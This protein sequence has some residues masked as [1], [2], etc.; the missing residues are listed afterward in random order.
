[1][2]TLATLRQRISEELGAWKTISTTAAGESG[3]TTLVSTEFSDFEEDALKEKY[4]K[5]TSGVTLETRKIQSVEALTGTVRPYRIFT[6]QIASGV[7]VELH[8]FDPTQI[9]ASINRAIRDAYPH[10]CKSIFDTTLISG[11]VLPNCSFEEWTSSSY[12]DYW[13]ASASTLT[14][15]TT[16]PLYSPTIMSV[17]NAGYA[18][19]ISD[20]WT[21][22]LDLQNSTVNLYG[23]A[24]ASAASNARLQ[25]YTK[26]H[27]GTAA[28]S[29]SD[30]HTGGSEWE[31]I[32]LESV[33]VPDEL[34]EIQIR[35]AVGSGTCYFD[36]LYLKGKIE[37]YLLPS[38]LTK[39]LQV[40]ECNDWDET[41]VKD[42]SSV[43]FRQLNKAGTNYIQV[44]GAAD[45]KKLEIVGYGEFSTLSS[46]T[47]S[48]TLTPAWERTIIYGAVANL[49]Q[50][51]S[52][53]MSTQSA[54]QSAAMADKYFKAFENGMVR[55]SIAVAPYRI[56]DLGT[57]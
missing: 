55:N 41:T 53:T 36:K 23:M 7:T 11:N 49:L 19:C 43:S 32:E 1:M 20:T 50:S 12:P 52:S 40:N 25:I 10:L 57:L 15:S 39:V 42:R 48:I 21:P 37:D 47:D 56:P 2:T 17:A 38:N 22:L 27:D 45:G 4:I 26:T 6:A 29:S 16:Y 30:Y 34:G 24:W 13:A 8:D 54:A 18:Y 46:D 14:K 9:H 5:V 44:Y 31:K 33:S 35:C 51:Q 3:G 28:T